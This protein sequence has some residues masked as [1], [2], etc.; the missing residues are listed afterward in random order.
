MC[1]C[2]KNKTNNRLFLVYELVPKGN[3]HDNLHKE[4][5]LP[6]ETRYKIVKDIAYAL[7]YLHHECDPF[8]LHRDIKPSNILLDDN[9]NAKLADFGLSRIV[10]NSDSS[11]ILTIPVGTEAYLDPQCKKPVGMV[12]FSRSSDVYSFGILLL[13][14]ACGEQAGMLIREKV[15]Q[16]YINRSLLRAADDRL[17]GEF[18]I[19]EMETV[20][21]LGLW[22]SYLD[23]NKRPS[24]EQ[25]MAVLEHGKQLPDLNSFDTTSVSAQMETYIDPQAP[26]SAASSSYEQM[27]E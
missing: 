14:I 13:E 17:K 24:M 9:F 2:W 26:T 25:V 7:L 4:E 12:E 22:C 6:W 20:L 15:W 10:D 8:I 19:S 16:L 18:S 23:N 11:R 3:L 27:H 21:I 5:T 1:W